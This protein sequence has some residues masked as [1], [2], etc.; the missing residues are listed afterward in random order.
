[1]KRDIETLK[2]GKFDLIIIGGGVTGAA[3]AWDASLR[4]LK[5]AL[6]EKNDFGH[7]TSAATSKLIHGG[8]RYLQN[9][10]FSVVRESLR[11]RRL[12]E[13]NMPHLAFPLPFIMPLYNYSPIPGF[14]LRIGLLLYDLLSMD[15]NDL[16]FSEKFLPN[17]QWLSKKEI[18]EMEPRLSRNGLK[19]GFLY[20]DVLN[21]YPERANLEY[22]ISAAEKGAQIA[23]Y[24]E[25]KSLKYEDSNTGEK[26]I[27]GIITTDKLTGQ[28]FNINGKIVINAS[29]PWVDHVLGK[30]T[31][32]MKK[33]ILRSKG[34]HLLL[35]KV[36]ENCAIAFSTR[37]KKHFFIIPW[38]NYTLLG[39]TDEKFT[40]DLDDVHVSRNEAEEFLNLV[41]DYYPIDFGIDGI[42]HVYAGIRPLAV[43]GD[44]EN[45][46][47]V[48]R[49]HEIISHFK[50]DQIKG[51]Y[52]VI[53]GKWTTSR[54]LAE[55]VVDKV[56]TEN[57]IPFEKSKT[58]NTPVSGGVFD[59]SFEQA[60]QRYMQKYS[61]IETKIIE[62]L[63][64]YYGSVCNKIIDRM[65]QNPKSSKLITNT[66]VYT[67]AEVE[68]CVEN[69]LVVKLS[70]FLMRRSCIGNTGIPHMDT[71]KEITE[72]IGNILKW[73]K[74]QKQKEIQEYIRQ[75]QMRNE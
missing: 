30:I 46:Y 71:L 29:G 23:N 5:T 12:L 19:G 16:P 61:S 26:N 7:A 65:K 73:S 57:K 11:E 1:M 20:Y 50:T 24:C 34:I 42:K 68:Y 53:G 44:S 45:T 55:I 6:I 59:S 52:T 2:N 13:K 58:A 31:R 35:P 72:I 69:E 67:V 3:M 25:F 32:N 15:K 33:K 36:N 60:L 47:T 9:F 27:S 28:D 37:D 66:D 39:T 41:K 17:H 48:S 40:G 64:T 75:Y 14:I 10:E 62:H 22:I 43:E 8:L 70:D 51:L 56:L 21:K 49:K 54:S 4:G 38:L 74:D 63:F 18:L